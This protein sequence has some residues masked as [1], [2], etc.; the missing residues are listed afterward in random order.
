M[1]T[2]TPFV[3]TLPKSLH[4]LFGHCSLERA[5]RR[6]VLW[7][8]IFENGKEHFSPTAQN[9]QTGQSGPS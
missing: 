3:Q 8:T 2:F 5:Y 7:T 4:T 1:E 9:E 6:V